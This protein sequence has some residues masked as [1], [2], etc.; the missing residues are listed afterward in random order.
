M[1]NRE[2]K[3]ITEKTTF[4]EAISINRNAAR[5]LAEHQ[6]F[7]GCCPMAM[8]ETIEQGARVHGVDIKKLLKEL[9]KNDN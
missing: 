5:I 8:M 9:N 3:I 1:K 4:G 6:M 7:C 2:K